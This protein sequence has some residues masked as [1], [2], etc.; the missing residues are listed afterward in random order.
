MH[1]GHSGVRT[2]PSAAQS[3]DVATRRRRQ[4]V[5]GRWRSPHPCMWWAKGDQRAFR[6]GWIRS[7]L[8]ITVLTRIFVR[9]KRPRNQSGGQISPHRRFTLVGM[10]P[11]A[12]GGVPDNPLDPIGQPGS[13][14]A[15]DA[16]PQST[17]SVPAA[18]LRVTSLHASQ[19]PCIRP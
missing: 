11:Q 14:P 13:Q 18:D 12:A 4:L 2:G 15:Y 7:A 3:D 19:K 17:A 5:C 1:T 8:S 16:D 10:C 9:S 6:S